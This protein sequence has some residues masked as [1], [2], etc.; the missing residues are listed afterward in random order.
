MTWDIYDDKM[1]TKSFCA[2]NGCAF[3]TNMILL[4]FELQKHIAQKSKP[5]IGDNRMENQSQKKKPNILLIM[6]D[7]MR[8]NQLR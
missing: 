8:G 7:Q 5:G 6:T 3:E 2:M 4:T 1:K